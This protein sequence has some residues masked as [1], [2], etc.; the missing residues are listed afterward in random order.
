MIWDD[1]RPGLRM[2][3]RYLSDRLRTAPHARSDTAGNPAQQAGGCQCGHVRFLAPAEPLAMYVCHCTEC[4]KQSSSA[5]G[6]SYTIPRERLEVTRGAVR[7][8]ARETVSGHT[9]DCAFCPECGSRLWHQSSGHPDT[10]NIKGGV[11]DA[12]LDVSEA[13]HLWIQ[14]RLPGV[15]IPANAV[16]FAQ[17]PV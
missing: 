16:C 12:P 3:A 8:W 17:D 1:E 13:I 10:L 11:L 9:L 2:P 5:F 6:I 7:Y 15:E 4:R 14:S